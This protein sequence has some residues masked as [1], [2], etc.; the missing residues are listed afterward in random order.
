M[1]TTNAGVD[2]DALIQDSRVH[3]WVYY[4]PAIF[5]DERER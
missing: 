3:A 4:A 1:A 2:Y 5:Q